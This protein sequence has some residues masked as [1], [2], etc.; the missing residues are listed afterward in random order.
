MSTV[1]LTAEVEDGARWESQFLTHGDLFK[2]Y[3]MK[4]PI[5]FTVNGNQVTMSSEVTDV[6][7]YLAVLKSPETLDAMKNDGVKRDTVQVMVLNKKLE[8]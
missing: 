5:E 8:F 1:I 7:A 6:D 3:P 2:S 4:S